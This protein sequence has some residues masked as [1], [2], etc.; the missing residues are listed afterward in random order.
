MGDAWHTITRAEDDDSR[1]YFFE[2]SMY[3]RVMISK[4]SEA[5]YRSRFKQ[6]PPPFRAIRRYLI[7]RLRRCVIR[8]IIL[9][10]LKSFLRHTLAGVN[11]VGKVISSD[12]FLNR[13]TWS[14]P[15]I[16]IYCFFLD[17]IPSVSV[18]TLETTTDGILSPARLIYR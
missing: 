11:C 5:P 7:N 3:G 18:T 15:N 4:S 16:F 2:Q 12:L 17:N 9:R 10:A 8:S 1:N 13:L 14:V 6:S